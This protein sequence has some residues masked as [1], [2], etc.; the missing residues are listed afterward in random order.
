MSDL[1]ASLASADT[2]RLQVPASVTVPAGYQEAAFD[3]TPVT[4]P[5]VNGHALVERGYA[6][7]AGFNAGGSSATVYDAQSLAIPV[8]PSPAH[9]ALRPWHPMPCCRGARSWGLARCPRVIGFIWEPLLHRGQAELLGSTA[10]TTWTPARSTRG[11]TYYWKV[12]AVLGEETASSPVWQFTVPPLGGLHHLTWNSLPSNALVETPFPAS[13]QA[14]DEYG[15][16]VDHD[17]QVTI[18]TRSGA[19][20]VL[21][22]EIGCDNIDAVEITNV[23][24]TSVDI[25]GWQIVLYDELSWPSP[26]STFTLPGGTVI[27]AGQVIRLEESATGPGTA[28]AFQLGGFLYWTSAGRAAVLIGMLRERWWISP[29][30]AARLRRLAIPSRSRS[31]SG[32]GSPLPSAIKQA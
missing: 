18:T 21:I 22:T 29:A 32:L 9:Q 13:L 8:N 17:G 16:V 23:S 19:A 3:L 12:V 2:A 31:D 24:H 1:V 14:V 11:T 15:D 26:I 27:G 6:Q 5:A 7:S 28:P 30:W 4:D 25:S 10:T 20:S